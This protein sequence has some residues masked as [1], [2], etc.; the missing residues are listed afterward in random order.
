MKKQIPVTSVVRF[1]HRALAQSAYFALQ[2]P[3]TVFGLGQ[4]PNFVETI[5][6]GIPNGKGNVRTLFLY[7]EF[8]TNFNYSTFID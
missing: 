5:T 6:V 3:Y 1:L 4:S 8:L 7:F 2:L